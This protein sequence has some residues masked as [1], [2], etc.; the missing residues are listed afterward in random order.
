[1]G[2]I[3]AAIAIGATDEDVAEELHFDLL[4][5]RAAATLAL[6]LAGVKAER[7]GIEAALFGEL[8]LGE[9]FADVIKCADIN[10]GI[11]AWRF[12]ENRLV[13]ENDAAK[14]FRTFKE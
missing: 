2:T 11:R 12:A 3:T 14:M 8:G 5:P 10:G 9:K 6:T 4:E 1:M 7:A 13:N